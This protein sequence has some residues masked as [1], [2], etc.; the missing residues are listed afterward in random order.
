MANV[1]GHRAINVTLTPSLLASVDAYTARVEAASPAF[2]VDRASVCRS[3]LIAGL[4]QVAPDL[5]AGAGNDGVSD[6]SANR[7]LQD[8][9]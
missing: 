8:A 9:Q 6:T 1:K 5:I 2:R 4:E 3:L 7:T